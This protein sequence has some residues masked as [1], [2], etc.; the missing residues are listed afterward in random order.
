[1]EVSEIIAVNNL[2]GLKFLDF[3]TVSVVARGIF[4]LGLSLLPIG[5]RAFAHQ[6]VAGLQT[7]EG[8]LTGFGIRFDPIDFLPDLALPVIV[9]IV[10]GKRNRPTADALVH[11]SVV[12]TVSVPVF[13]FSSADNAKLGVIKNAGYSVARV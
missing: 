6:V 5:L 12:A 11:P 9:I 8:I 10:T 7:A 2:T 13:V 3:V 4:F 1:M